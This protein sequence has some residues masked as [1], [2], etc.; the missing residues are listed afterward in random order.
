MASSSVQCPQY[1]VL[2]VA[3]ILNRYNKILGAKYPSRRSTG[4][5]ADIRVFGSAF[6][7]GKKLAAYCYIDI[8]EFRG[9]CRCS[10]HSA[11]I[12]RIGLCLELALNNN[13]RFT[14]SG[15]AVTCN[16][17]DISRR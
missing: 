16:T 10:H 15:C 8:G 11:E 9:G 12:H 3:Y 6:E 4:K 2:E 17:S 14:D 5:T 7:V 1:I 13:L